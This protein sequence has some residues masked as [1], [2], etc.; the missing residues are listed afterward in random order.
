MADGAPGWP[1]GDG[2]MAAEHNGAGE[3]AGRL[4]HTR[5]ARCAEAVA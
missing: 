4:L 3:D 1:P 2:I 5:P